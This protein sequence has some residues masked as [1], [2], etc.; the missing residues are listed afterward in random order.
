MIFKYNMFNIKYIMASEDEMIDNDDRSKQEG[1]SSDFIKI[2]SDFC[3]DIGR[4]FSQELTKES[5]VYHYLE[6]IENEND[7]EIK[8]LTETAHKFCCENYPKY[9]F[10]ILYE[11]KELFSTNEKLELL[12]SLN[13]IP[14][15]SLEL[16][17][18]TRATIWKYLQLILFTIVSEIKTDES[19]GDTAKLFEAINSSEFKQKIEATLEEMEA[20]FNQNPEN[21]DG[22]VPMDLPKAEELHDHINKMMEGKLGCLA[23]EIAEETAEDLDIDMTDATS[24]NDV[25]SKLFKNPTKLMGLVKNVGSKLD[26]KIKSGSIKESEL[27]EEASEFVANMKNMPGMGNLEAMFSKMGVPGMGGGG[28][29]DMNALNQQMA[30]NLRAAKMRDR[31]RTKLEKRNQQE[32]SKAT[33]TSKGVNDFGMQELVYSLGESAEKS[34]P[35]R[36]GKK[37]R[38][39]KPVMVVPGNKDTDVDLN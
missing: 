34:K 16:T 30:H 17:D 32:E 18:A 38:K 1:V 2:L 21:E 22:Q 7:E 25:F 27:F 14:L 12:P 20:I 13:F 26:T 39:K 24:V 35:N 15:W 8:L 9:F 5:F 6:A 31:M 10:D 11:N 3:K 4:T 28:K 29:V 37:N 36:R 23:K 33:I 19:F